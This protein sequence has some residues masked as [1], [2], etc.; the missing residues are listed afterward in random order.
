MGPAVQLALLVGG[1]EELA[2]TVHVGVLVLAVGAI[3]WAAWWLDDPLESLAL[4]SAATLILLPVTWY[5]YPAALIP[6][7][8]AAVL[9]DRQVRTIAL[10]VASGVLAAF[11]LTF[12]VLLWVAAGLV[13]LAARATGPRVALRRAAA[14]G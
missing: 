4:A 14:P 8:A 3:G 12:P 9:R 10:V 6:F 2:R 5:H 1:G 13:V 7:A 11:G